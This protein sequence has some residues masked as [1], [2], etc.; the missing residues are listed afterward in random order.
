[1]V[2]KIHYWVISLHEGPV[3]HL[4]LELSDGTYISHH[5]IRSKKPDFSG[6]LHSLTQ[7]IENEKRIP[8]QT[9]HLYDIQLNER[10]I[11]NWWNDYRKTSE[12]KLLF[13]NCAQIVQKALRI[14]GLRGGRGVNVTAADVLE[15][16]K[17]RDQEKEFSRIMQT[18][19]SCSGPAKMKKY[20]FLRQK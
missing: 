1:M 20:Y 14:G 17:S 9:F 18:W 5:P 6:A 13:D 7:D 16:T 4:S 3:G 15:W 2:V 19:S 8:D 11:K 12:Y 10:Q